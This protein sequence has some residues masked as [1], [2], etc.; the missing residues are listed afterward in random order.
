MD[1][2]DFTAELLNVEDD[3][4]I[5]TVL[6][7]LQEAIENAVI[8]NVHG[9]VWSDIHGLTLYLPDSS[10]AGYMSSYISASYGLDLISDTRWPELLDSIAT[11]FPIPTKYADYAG[12]SLGDGFSNR[13]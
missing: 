4:D 3:E 10:S 7:G 11:G 1:L 2:Y 6:L 5:R 9:A 12:P 8:A 13:R